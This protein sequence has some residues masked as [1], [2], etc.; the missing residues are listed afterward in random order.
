M[1]VEKLIQIMRQLQSFADRPWYL[2]LIALLGGLDLFILIV[3]TD[4]LLISYVMLRP[5]HWVRAFIALSIGCTLGAWALAFLIQSGS[6]FFDY[7]SLHHRIGADTWMWIDN[8]VDNR[9]ALALG[10]LALLPLPQFP[11]IVVAAL[12]E[13]PLTEIFFAVLAG[14]VIKFAVF[15]YGASHAPKLLLKLPLLKKEVAV[16]AGPRSPI[17]KVLKE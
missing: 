3:P 8:F 6:S 5:K 17:N 15:S 10:I 1:I 12:A 14:R 4:G 9:G 11:G 7:Q 2:P 16:M 13:L